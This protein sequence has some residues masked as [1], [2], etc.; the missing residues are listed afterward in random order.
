LNSSVR[1]PVS[2]FIRFTLVLAFVL[3][4]TRA[5]AAPPD[6]SG[7]WFIDLRTPDERQRKIECGGA[8]F[9]LKQRGDRIVGSHD[10]A[11]A[12]CGR[13]NEG[14]EGTVKGIVVNG[15]AVLVVTSGRNGG[16]VVGTAKLKG[17]KLHWQGVEEIRPG[18]PEGDSPLILWSGVLTRKQE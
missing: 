12:G 15:T 16:V 5:S 9:Q 13:L 8:E 18:E 7:N 11:T 2:L 3:L 17:G 1:L 14:G 10:M 4:S 6:F